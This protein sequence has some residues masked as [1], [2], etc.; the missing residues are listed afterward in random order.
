MTAWLRNR[1][2]LSLGL[3]AS[4]P[5]LV[6]AVVLLW[7]PWVPVLDMAMTELRVRDVGGPNTPLVGLP[8]RIGEFPDQ[9]SHPGPWSFFLVAPLYR[10][11][12]STAWGMELASVVVNSVC[13]VVL[14]VMGHRRAGRLGVIT[15][16][17]IGALA[18]RG[19]GLTV[20]THP[21]N[22]Y[23]PVLLWMLALVAAWCVLSGDHWFAPV[24]A[25]ASVVAA[26]THIPYLASAIAVNV[27]VAGFLVWRIVV[28]RRR[29]DPGPVRPLIVMSGVVIL[30]WIPPLIQQLQDGRDQGNIAKI[31]RHFA[32]DQPEPSIGPGPA[33]ELVT[34]RFDV[35]SIAAGMFVRD[36]AFVHQAGQYGSPSVVGA[37]VVL[38]WVASAAWAVVRR[39][40]TLL[41]LHAVVAC[42]LVA[43]WI[44]LSRIFGKVWF[45]L[46][47]WMSS[48]VVLAVL[49]IL[50]TAWIIV[51]ERSAGPGPTRG[52]LAGAA[53]AVGAVVTA[54]SLV[55]VIGH[56]P[57]ED[58]LGSD[59]RSVMG[60][61]TDALDA[62]MGAATG[63]AGSYVVFWQESEAPG[64]RGYA[65]LNELERR[66]YRV[67]VHP[68]WRIPATE[69]RVRVDGEYDAEV[70]IVSGGW[71]DLWRE[72]GYVEVLEFDGR[73][74]EQRARFAELDVRVANRL[75]EIGRED[76]VPSVG[77]NIFRTSL[78]AGLPD[79][80]VADLDEMLH[81]G[82]ELAIF[83]APPGSTA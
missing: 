7:R 81:L 32:T 64:T 62:G 79:D 36:D 21:W 29:G 82:E 45:Y 74:D 11:A 46:S 24:V 66:G 43:G 25:G 17:V 31:V 3:A 28:D 49:A 70:H 73:T 35:V 76:L 1:P 22:P 40:R 19:Y 69:H 56:E 60:E 57:P 2:A 12:G 51:R 4:V 30:L 54:L 27:L 47:L 26:Q 78:E 44:S 9:G 53:L 63:E 50:W 71:I 10:L 41:A 59:L 77:E 15:F 38:L 61:I 33:W 8:G 72:R 20:L 6:T 75:R 5:L 55:A 16:A 42:T 34:Q 14:A 68:S 58:D 80:I 48:T 13:I 23:F 18:V 65:L 67:G 52:H 37:L 39:H 83:I